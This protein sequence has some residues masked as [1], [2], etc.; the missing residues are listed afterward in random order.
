ME[1][2][3]PDVFNV[4][5]Q[6]LD[7][8]RLTDSQG[9]TVNFKNTIVIMTSNIGSQYLLDGVNE[10][11]EISETAREAV[12]RALRQT[13]KPEFLNRMDETVL[14]KPLTLKEIEKIVLLVLDKTRKRV[15]EQGFKL[16]V[17]DEAAAYIAKH[18]YSAQYGARPVKR[19]VQREVET[20]IARMVM[21]GETNDGDTVTVNIRDGKLTIE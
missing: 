2:G 18:S 14:F 21:M 17:T 19:Y 10:T 6:L 16:S 4:L 11:G 9:R 20:K 12:N 15:S 8:G 5:L 3:H 1:K 13:F 7:D